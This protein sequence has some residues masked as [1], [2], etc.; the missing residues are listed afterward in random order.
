MAG[1]ADLV[2][3]ARRFKQM[4][5]GGFRQAGMMAAGALYALEHQRERLAEDHATA[6]R[7]AAGLAETPGVEVDPRGVSTNM[8]YF[9]VAMPAEQFAQEWH[10]SG[11]A[12]LPMDATTIRAVTH[13]G[14]TADDIDAALRAAG[15]VLA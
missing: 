8:V 2:A 10:A 6:A 3:T 13:I 7:L 14:I 11:V 4:L 12:A 5:G 15:E 1:R 9:R